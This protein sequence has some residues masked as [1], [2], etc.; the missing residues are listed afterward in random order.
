MNKP[1]ERL[2]NDASPG[3]DYVQARPRHRLLT[4]EP[5]SYNLYKQERDKTKSQEK[6]KVRSVHTSKKRPTK[7]MKIKK[8]CKRLIRKMV[9]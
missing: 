7:E 5:K 9:V 8:R 4:P 6:K 2:A 1:D 3:K